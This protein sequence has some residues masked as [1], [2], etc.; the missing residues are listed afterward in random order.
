M[1]IALRTII[2]HAGI[3]APRRVDAVPEGGS[4]GRVPIRSRLVGGNAARRDYDAEI[5][6]KLSTGGGTE[7]GCP[8]RAYPCGSFQFR[9]PPFKGNKGKACA[10]QERIGAADAGCAGGNDDARQAGAVLEHLIADAGNAV[11]Y[12]NAAGEIG[13]A[14]YEYNVGSRKQYIVVDR[15]VRV[16]RVNRNACQIGAANECTNVDAGYAVGYGDA[17][18]AGAAV[19]RTNADAG[20]AVGYFYAC[21][22]AC[23]ANTRQAGAALERTLVDAGYAVGYSDARQAGAVL[24]RNCADAGNAVGYGNAAGEIGADGYEYNSGSRKQYIVVGGKV[25]VGRVNRNVCQIG[26]VLEHSASDGGYAATDVHTGQA[27][28]SR[29]RT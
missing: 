25:R 18:Q 28:A 9:H 2:R 23:S 29:E 22:A 19:E 3:A 20:Y 13:C 8:R 10:A 27:G 11:G 14:G 4:G 21:P 26:A 15:K 17:R 7:R 5:C 16:C 6:V 1:L 24:E 12:G